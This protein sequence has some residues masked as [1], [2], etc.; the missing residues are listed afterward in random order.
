MGTVIDVSTID[1]ED[2]Q[3]LGG[4][5]G[6]PIDGAVRHMIAAYNA[7]RLSDHPSLIAQ[8][9]ALLFAIGAAI[10]TGA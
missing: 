2:D 5:D 7:I 4:Y 10:S 9:R 6:D 8:T 3:W 1:L